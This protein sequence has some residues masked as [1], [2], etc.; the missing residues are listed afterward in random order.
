MHGLAQTVSGLMSIVH[1]PIELSHSWWVYLVGAGGY[2][3]LVFIDEITKKRRLIFSKRNPRPAWA[4]LW[5]HAIFLVFLMD[6]IQAAPSLVLLLPDFMTTLT[7]SHTYYLPPFMWFLCGV[8]ALSLIERK[9]LESRLPTKSSDSE[10]KA[11]ASES[12]EENR[13]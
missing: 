8:I 2:T 5:I 13:R 11:G 6:Y 4:T 12:T 7:Q 9:W 1:P 10:D 3:L